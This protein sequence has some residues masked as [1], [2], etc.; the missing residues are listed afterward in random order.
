MRERERERERERVTAS[1]AAE[2]AVKHRHTLNEY[3]LF[4]I[5]FDLMY[6]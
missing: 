6:Q 4:I 3:I 1:C 5:I 2:N